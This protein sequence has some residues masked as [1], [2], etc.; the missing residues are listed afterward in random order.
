[1]LA[2]VQAGAVVNLLALAAACLRWLPAYHTH[3]KFA[4]SRLPT[5]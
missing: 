2:L 5:L 1:M 4:G 3:V